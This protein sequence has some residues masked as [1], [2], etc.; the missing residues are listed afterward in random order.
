MSTVLAEMVATLAAFLEQD[1]AEKRVWL[2]LLLT[3]LAVMGAA[4]THDLGTPDDGPILT[5]TERG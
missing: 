2:A 1:T 4:F 3:F 5:E